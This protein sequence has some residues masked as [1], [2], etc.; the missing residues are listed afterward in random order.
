MLKKISFLF[1]LFI[2]LKL[3]TSLETNIDNVD[4]YK[5]QYYQDNTLYNIDDIKKLSTPYLKDLTLDQYLSI[6]RGFVKGLQNFINPQNAEV[7]SNY[8]I[9][10]INHSSMVFNEGQNFLLANSKKIN[11]NSN[12]K[13]NG[14]VSENTQISSIMNYNEI[15]NVI[16]S[17]YSDEKVRYVILQLKNFLIN[18]KNLNNN[19]CNEKLI[20]EKV[21]FYI[22]IY[23]NYGIDYL[24]DR[25][26]GFYQ[27]NK[28][29]FS[30]YVNK[31][32]IN[33]FFGSYENLGYNLG[34]CVG[35]FL[36]SPYA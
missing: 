3:G 29:L 28:Y 18:L 26:L 24:L 6:A 25:E 35:V 30:G 16:G 22:K 10:T 1:L 27:S 15:N 23:K 19:E 9:N 7:C 12:M 20:F 5:N 4:F 14:Q 8:L 21:Q 11:P 31:M 33:L 13:E 32:M 17:Y 36:S 34:S 2:F